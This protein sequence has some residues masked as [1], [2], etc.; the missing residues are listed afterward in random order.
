[1]ISFLIF[2]LIVIVVAIVIVYVVELL[3][4]MLPGVPANVATIIRIIVVL[5]ALLCSWPS[6]GQQP[7]PDDP[8][9]PGAHGDVFT[10]TGRF[11]ARHFEIASAAHG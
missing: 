5:I 10:L 4:G 1:M 3:L 8:L 7:G 2:A 11:G 6:A 9:P